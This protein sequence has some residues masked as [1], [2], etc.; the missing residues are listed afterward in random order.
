MK[1]WAGPVLE[2]QV[3][4]S[5]RPFAK[6]P[7]PA[8][9]QVAGDLPCR[10][11]SYNLRGLRREGD[12]PECGTPIALSLQGDLLRFADPSWLRRVRLGALLFT[13]G[14]TALAAGRFVS[15]WVRSSPLPAALLVIMTSAALLAGTWFVTRMDPGGRG[16]NRGELGRRAGRALM[17]AAFAVQ[18]FHFCQ[19][20]IGGTAWSNPTR[21]GILV[22]AAVLDLG[23]ELAACWYMGELALRASDVP[24]ARR[25]RGL[26]AAYAAARGFWAIGYPMYLLHNPAGRAFPGG[27]ELYL[28]SRLASQGTFLVRLVGIVFLTR[29]VHLLGTQIDR[30]RE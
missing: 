16:E 25:L 11:C 26:G 29:F 20:L 15:V 12:C 23:G 18:C 9:E 28:L 3:S 2:A 6:I 10:R 14:W 8:P 17:L 13:C 7:A 21:I 5:D 19:N 4:M 30:R 27:Y 22:L 24:L 1:A